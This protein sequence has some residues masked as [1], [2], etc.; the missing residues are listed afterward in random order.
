MSIFKSIGAWFKKVFTGGLQDADKIAILVTQGVK[1]ALLDGAL[2]FIADLLDGLTKSQVPTE[3]VNLIRANIGKILAVELAIQ[4]IPSSPSQAD[5]LAFEQDVLNAFGVVSDKSKLYTVLASQ[6]Y[7]IIQ[8]QVEA[9][10]KFTF[11][12]LVADVEQSYIDYTND[13]NET[14]A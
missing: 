7:G 5:I 10:T 3:I 1:E 12:Q 14:S 11:A 13:Q 4:G 6:I 9:G 8:A 2:G